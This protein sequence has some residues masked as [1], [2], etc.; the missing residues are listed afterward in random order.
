MINVLIFS[1]DR[2]CQLDLC[3]RSIRSRFKSIGTIHVLYNYTN[4]IYRQGYD[5]VKSSHGR[6]E[7]HKENDFQKDTKDIIINKFDKELSLCF[8]DDEIIFN[9]IDEPDIRQITDAF[10]ND[11]RAVAISLKLHKGVTY[12]YSAQFDIDLPEFIN[13]AVFLVWDW[14][15]SN[16]NGEW[17]YPHCING[18][19]YRTDEFKA[20]I[21][22]INFGFPNELEGRMNENR[23][24]NKPLLYSFLT[25]RVFCIA[26]NYVKS[27]EPEQIDT[28]HSVRSLND[29]FLDGNIIDLD[30][31]IGYNTNM[32]QGV[33]PYRF[34]KR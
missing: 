12:C 6:I 22:S 14:T 13:D 32:I 23:N 30:P 4:D 15:K 8:V 27:A 21:N 17:G 19:I 7:W 26:N 3:I 11:S 10:K 16:P 29:K 33:L 1:L 9:P 34:I 24:Y 25:P 28:E 2:A 31:L 18:H 20:L 5:I